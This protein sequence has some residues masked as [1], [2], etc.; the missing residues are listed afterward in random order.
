MKDKPTPDLLADLALYMHPSI[1]LAY[2]RNDIFDWLGTTITQSAPDS[3]GPHQ[4]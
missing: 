3:M 4:L 1:K 2:T